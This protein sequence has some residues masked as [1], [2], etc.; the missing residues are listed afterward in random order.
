MVKARVTFRAFKT[1]VLHQTDKVFHVEHFVPPQ[2]YVQ[3]WYVH[4]NEATRE[5]SEEWE[6]CPNQSRGRGVEA[7]S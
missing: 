6:N 2:M 7:I 3:C 1:P 5:K 4:E